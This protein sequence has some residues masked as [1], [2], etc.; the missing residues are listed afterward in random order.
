VEGE[1][2]FGFGKILYQP[3]APK[4]HDSYFDKTET[5]FK[6]HISTFKFSKLSRQTVHYSQPN[7][8]YTNLNLYDRNLYLILTV[9]NLYL[10]T[11]FVET[12]I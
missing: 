11:T 10:E 7:H 8:T 4:I 9:I 2:L 6:I 1:L 12:Q 5:H 3:K